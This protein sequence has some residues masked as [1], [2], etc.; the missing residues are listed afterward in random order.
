MQQRRD[1]VVAA[2]D[3]KAKERAAAAAAAAEESGGGATAGA[4]AGAALSP[5]ALA[6]ELA[7]RR[8]ELEKIEALGSKIT[9]ELAAVATRMSDAEAEVGAL[10]D[11]GSARRAAE[12]R[13]GELEAA[14]ED[15][16]RR[17]DAVKVRF[18]GFRLQ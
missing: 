16:A 12:A 14:R 15:A 7:A 4:A 8:A 9:D 10:S 17:R 2:L 18:A 3:C 11:V 13:L 6:A 5:E 1:A